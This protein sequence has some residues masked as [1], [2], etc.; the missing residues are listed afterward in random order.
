MGEVL[1][2]PIARAPLGDIADALADAGY[3]VW[4]LTPRADA[5]AIT[6]LT[7]PARLALL[8]GAEGPGL[9]A[10]ALARHTPVRIPIRSEVD[11]LNVGHALAAALAVVATSSP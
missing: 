9:S 10:E 3:A 5:A 2:L 4:A 1:H 6:T 11:S 8:L 7:P